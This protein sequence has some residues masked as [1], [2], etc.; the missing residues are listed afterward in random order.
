MEKW[1]DS[2]GW[3]LGYMKL[4]GEGTK[5]WSIEGARGTRV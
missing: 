3:R 2:E 4:V 5:G 1:G